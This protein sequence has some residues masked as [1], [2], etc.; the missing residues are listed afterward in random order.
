MTTWKRV[1]ISTITGFILGI[2]CWLGGMFLFGYEYSPLQITTILVHRTVMGFVIGV[3]TLPIHWALRGII[4]GSIVGSLFILYDLSAG[5][6]TWIALLL[7]GVNA[8][9]GL[10]IEWVSLKVAPIAQQLQ[11]DRS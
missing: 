10:V 2:F 5:Y 11:K 3:T 7:L 8:L 1:G 6:P 9:Y 4:L